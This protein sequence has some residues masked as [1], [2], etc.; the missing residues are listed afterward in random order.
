MTLQALGLIL[1]FLGHLKAA[2][3]PMRGLGEVSGTNMGQRYFLAEILK[4]SS[5]APYDLMNFILERRIEPVWY[6][7]ALPNGALGM[8]FEEL[9]TAEK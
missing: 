9:A 3:L 4:K 6:N 2:D 8:A 1:P 7:I 5:I